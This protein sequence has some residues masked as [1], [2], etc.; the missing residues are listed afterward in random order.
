MRSLKHIL[1]IGYL[2]GITLIII[3]LITDLFVWGQINIG[4]LDIAI[5]TNGI[6]FIIIPS[7]LLIEKIFIKKLSYLN[8]IFIF[9]S[10]AIIVLTITFSRYY[11]FQNHVSQWKIYSYEAV[12]N[13]GEYN[14]ISNRFSIFDA[15]KLNEKGIKFVADPIVKHDDSGYYMFFEAY[16]SVISKGS[17]GLATSKDAFSWKYRKIILKEP[18]HLSFPYVFSENNEYFMIPESSADSSIRL[19]SST[20]LAGEWTF[21]KTILK[22]KSFIDNVLVKH[23]EVFYLFTSTSNCDLLL[24][25]STRLDSGWKTH[26]K[27]PIYS[28]YC[29]GARMAGPI[30]MDGKSMIR[31]AQD[32][33]PYYGNNIRTFIINRLDTLNYSES[34][35]NSFPNFKGRNSNSMNGIHTL[36]LISKNGKDI[37]VVDTY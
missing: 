35:I 29:D 25:Y 8:Q 19:Y 36:N 2:L 21:F 34:E 11:S 5:F 24:Y 26:P 33:Y 30:L 20:S 10:T 3:P 37:F 1:I 27:S 23:N 15:K 31:I 14:L 28:N 16:D 7:L 13:G 17:I 9:I 6:A 18:F 12:K 22:G 32:D 4:F